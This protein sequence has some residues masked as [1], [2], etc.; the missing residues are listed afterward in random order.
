MSVSVVFFRMGIKYNGLTILRIDS[1]LEIIWDIIPIWGQIFMD[2]GIL[3][4]VL[5]SLPHIKVQSKTKQGNTLCTFL[6]LVTGLIATGVEYGLFLKV[7]L[8]EDWGEQP[9][10][11]YILVA[12]FILGWMG[13]IVGYSHSRKIATYGNSYLDLT[14]TKESAVFK[15]PMIESIGKQCPKCDHRCKAN[16][17]FCES[18]GNHFERTLKGD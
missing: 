4:A 12:C 10:L 9:D 5:T 17:T 15:S 6:G 16:A 3:G 18:C 14:S 2:F 1:Q 8:F 7:W 13:L 11:N